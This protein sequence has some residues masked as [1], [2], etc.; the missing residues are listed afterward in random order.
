M[1]ANNNSAENIL[2][3]VTG[4]NQPT[5]PEHEPERQNVAGR[6]VARPKKRGGRGKTLGR[7][8]KMLFSF[9]P[10][11]LPLVI[12]CIVISAVLS[13]LPA[14]FMQRTL[15]IV[16][17]T[18]ES[19]D[20]GA[21]AGSITSLVLTLVGIYVV[22]LALNFTWTRAMAIITQGSLEKFREKLFGHMQDL[23]ISFFDQH[24]RGDIMSHYTNDIDALR[25][26]IGQSLP[27][28]TLTFVTCCSV[29]A[30]MVYYSVWM[31]N[32][33]AQQKEIG[34]VE[35]HVEEVMNGQRVVKV[36]CHE[37]AAQEDFDVRNRRLFEASRAANMYTNTLGPI[38][39]N[40][41]N[42]LYVI[43]A[44]MGGV[45]IETGIPNL[46]ISGLPFSI[47]VTV[48]FLNMTKQFAG[49]I[50]QI[51]QQINSV[52]MGLAGAERIFE[53][54]DEPVEHDEGYVELVACK[55]SSSL[56]A[57]STATERSPSASA[58]TTTGRASG[59]GATLMATAA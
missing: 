4:S 43:V 23:P 39:M 13:A 54:M 17:A 29:I 3:N 58:A 48:P 11:M 42:L 12:L 41:G 38:L 16:T 30:V 20:W 10:K 24:Q 25:Q 35:G 7:L 56:P 51:S 32:F 37:D 31:C 50:G 21:V 44:L 14:T 53:M 8:I 22:S 18:W 40:L 27:N 52:V 15:E 46:S 45:F 1:A 9:Y 47:A 5:E 57:R 55:T 26:M 19:G 49:Q 6:Q 33:V 2:R 59:H 28:I 34:I 36:F